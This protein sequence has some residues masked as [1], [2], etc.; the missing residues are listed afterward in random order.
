MFVR[1]V[2]NGDHHL[3]KERCTAPDDI[4]VSVRKRVE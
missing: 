1:V 2:E 3:V 4:Q